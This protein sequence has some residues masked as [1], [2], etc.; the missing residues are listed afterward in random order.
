MTGLSGIIGVVL[1]V[2]G[3]STQDVSYTIFGGSFLIMEAIMAVA[4]ELSKIRQLME[5][6]QT[7]PS[8]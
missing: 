4:T 8:K 2:I 5:K 1:C 3:I 7:P 6:S